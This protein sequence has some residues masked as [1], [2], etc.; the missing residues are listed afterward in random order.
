MKNGSLEIEILN[1]I[2]EVKTGSKSDRNNAITIQYFGLD[3]SGGTS[4]ESAGEAYSLTRESV[5]QI[6]NKVRAE[7]SGA[8]SKFPA[9]T[10]AI[11][12]IDSMIPASADDIE[13]HLVEKG[14]IKK[15]YMIEGII[16]AAM[17][18]GA[19]TKANQ[20]I[21][22]NDIRYVVSLAHIDAAKDVQ[23]LATKEIS[24]NGAVSLQLL[25]A[26]LPGVKSDIKKSFVL[27]VLNSISE[28]VWV[29]N[30]EWLYFSDKGRNRFL[31]RLRK[32]FSVM[33]SVSSGNLRL[34]MIRSWKKSEKEGSRVIP[35]KVMISIISTLPGFAI[36]GPIISV[37]K[38][39]DRDEELSDTEEK[40]ILILKESKDG[41]IREKELEDAIVLEPSE[42][43]K[44]SMALNYSPILVRKKRGVYTLVG[45]PI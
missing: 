41:T 45:K 36:N 13:S 4:M 38:P 28:T 17:I 21:K 44:F 27:S 26:S 32:I 7:I 25:T 15:G 23:S 31:S 2:S 34:A 16:N 5:R 14:L 30:G 37:E 18:F 19:A 35:E 39:F 42:K 10:E 12:I 24:H 8:P 20:V 11:K 22:H 9:L 29:S 43:F 40:I 1:R 33:E 3:G 6:T